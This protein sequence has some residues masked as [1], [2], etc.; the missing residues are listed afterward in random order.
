M[1]HPIY[2]DPTY[3]SAFEGYKRNK[4]KF[5]VMTLAMGDAAKG[6]RMHIKTMDR[7]SRQGHV[8]IDIENDKWES[9]ISKKTIGTMNVSDIKFPFMS[10]AIIDRES[11]AGVIFFSIDDTYFH[12]SFEVSNESGKGMLS[13]RIL[14]RNTVSEGLSSFDTHIN[15]MYRVISVLMYVSA[16][17]KE[18][19]RV[20]KRVSNK[21]KASKRRSIPSHKI[22][23]I[24]VRQPNSEYGGYAGGGGKSSMSWIVKGHWRNQWYGKEGVNKPKW[25]DP[26]FKGKGK[27]EI[28]KVYKV[29]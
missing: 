1:N 26:Y 9:D 29:S 19:N 2:S 12:V 21:L 13:Q 10:G 5:D 7:I 6:L 15:E 20:I 17:R 16:F 27:D 11:D 23:T 24:L 14:L 4:D 18:K 8:L 25:I 28:D 3:A 22:H